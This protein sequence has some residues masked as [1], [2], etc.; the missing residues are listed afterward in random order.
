MQPL[1]KTARLEYGYRKQTRKQGK[2]R[3]N[4]PDRSK[5]HEPLRILYT[6]HDGRR[7]ESKNA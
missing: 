6:G 5:L 4:R 3:F 7:L 1:D 2:R